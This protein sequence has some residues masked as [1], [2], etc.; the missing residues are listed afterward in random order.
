MV[1]S[2]VDGLSTLLAFGIYVFQV[3]RPLLERRQ[4]RLERK[5]EKP[6]CEKQ[7]VLPPET[8]PTEATPVK[9]STLFVR[10]FDLLLWL[11]PEVVKFPRAHRF[12]LAERVQRCAL[13]F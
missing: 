5:P 6:N 1:L 11:I 12:G 13:D 3:A 10:T 2:F 9:E 4:K 8:K 7:P